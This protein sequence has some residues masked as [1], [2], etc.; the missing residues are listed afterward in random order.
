MIAG[1]FKQKKLNSYAF[2]YNWGTCMM[3]CL[4]DCTGF[5]FLTCRVTK[6]D[7]QNG[8]DT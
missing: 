6:F 1:N 4:F 3:I 8:L 5:L 7:T 2:K